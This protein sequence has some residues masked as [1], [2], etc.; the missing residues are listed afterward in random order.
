MSELVNLFKITIGGCKM[1]QF[2][3]FLQNNRNH[4][5]KFTVKSKYNH[6]SSSR[7]ECSQNALK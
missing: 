7:S 5:V 2:K 3:I 6:R 1:M 4:E